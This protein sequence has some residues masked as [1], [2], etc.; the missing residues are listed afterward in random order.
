MRSNNEQ[1]NEMVNEDRTKESITVTGI[2]AKKG[3]GIVPS[4]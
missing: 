1:S 3:K 2:A 4:K